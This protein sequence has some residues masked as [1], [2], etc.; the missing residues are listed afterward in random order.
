MTLAQRLA[1][2][3]AETPAPQGEARA[4]GAMSLLDWAACGLAG[5]GEPVARAVRA[6]AAEEGGTAQ[7]SVFGLAG[8]IPARAAALV[9]G[10]TSHALDYDDT[11]FLHIGHPSVVCAPA[12]LAAAERAGATG[13]AFLDAFLIGFETACRIGDWL[14]RAHYEAGFHQ[15]ATAGAFGAA[16]AACRAMGLDAATTAQALAL[17]TTRAS[18]LKSQ[19]GAMGKPYNAG[20]AAAAGL[21]CALLAA[22][23]VRSNPAALE[24]PQGFGPTHAGAA[25]A[26]AWDGLGEAWALAGVSHKLH[27][28]CHGTHAAIEALRS[29]AVDPAAVRGVTVTVNPR[30]LAVCDL[31]EP[32]DGLEAKFSYRLTA[33]MALAGVDTAALES[34]DAALCARP[35]LV[36]LR[37]RVRV[38]ADATLPD[39][40]ARVAVATAEGTLR[41][42]H[43]LDAPAPVEARAARVAAKAAALIGPARAQALQAA[44]AGLD[45]APSAEGFA[46]LLRAEAAAA[47]RSA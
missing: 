16:A 13:R 30:W 39:T 34:F 32:R 1:A 6:M 43:D 21:E 9:N 7:A 44:L 11:H 37:D 4:V 14:G 23:G 17:A 45:G 19:F 8:R 12:A 36:A 27:A 15:T 29:L 28:C 18:G 33:A 25:R 20:L 22:Q 3:A 2:F 35:D 10:A 47:R 38:E 41:A 46:A 5:V 42:A 24:G 31:P 40:A 26:G